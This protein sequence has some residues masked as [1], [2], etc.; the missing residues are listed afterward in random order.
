MPA[1]LN[2]ANTIEVSAR[3]TEFGEHNRGLCPR[4]QIWRTQKGLVPAKQN[5]ANTEG[6]CAREIKIREHRRLNF[7]KYI[8]K[9]IKLDNRK[10][11]RKNAE[12]LNS[13]NY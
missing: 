4:K 5:L 12:A 11:P 8:S 6:V 3:E 1:K 7:P 10:N 13:K 2:L 9:G